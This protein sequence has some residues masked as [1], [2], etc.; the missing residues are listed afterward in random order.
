MTT[1]T[2][3]RKDRELTGKELSAN[4]LASILVAQAV[5]SVGDVSISRPMAKEVMLFLNRAKAILY[6]SDSGWF[7]ADG[8]KLFLTQSGLDEV[9]AREAGVSLQSNGKKREGMFP[10]RE[11]RQHDVLSSWVFRMKPVL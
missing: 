7:R 5:N 3:Y 1:K 4:T 6:W 9:Q 10:P 11:S 8:D 2:I